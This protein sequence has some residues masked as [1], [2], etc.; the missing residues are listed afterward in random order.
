MLFWSDSIEGLEIG[1][2]GL[3][4]KLFY[5]N[6]DSCCDAF[7]CGD[8]VGKARDIVGPDYGCVRKSVN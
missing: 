3:I 2:I 4:L 7:R 8:L 6:K 1:V 5:V